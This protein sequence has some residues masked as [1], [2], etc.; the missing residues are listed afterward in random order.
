MRKILGLSLISIA[1]LSANSLRAEELKATGTI[2]TSCAFLANNTGSLVAS[3][4]LKNLGTIYGS[5]PRSINYTVAV[6]GGANLDYSEPST[7]SLNGSDISNEVAMNES[8]SYRNSQGNEVNL[9][10]PQGVINLTTN[11]YDFSQ[12]VSASKVDNSEFKT[13]QYEY[14]KTIFCTGGLIDETDNTGETNTETGAEIP[15]E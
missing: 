4:D 12:D 15:Q 3:N 6:S 11:V 8:V 10:N 13:G 7:L 14:V 1:L 2:S 5:Q 9:G